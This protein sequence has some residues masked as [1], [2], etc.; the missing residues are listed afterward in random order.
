MTDYFEVHER[1]G[2]ARLGEVRLAEPVSKPALAD[3]FIDDAG[4]LWAGDREVPAGDAT[5]LTVL[6]H[7]AF[8]AGTRDEVRESFAVDHPGVAFPSAAVVDSRSARDLGADAYL[9]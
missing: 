4:S 5:A 7:R 6:H 2:A 9:L 8:P 1:D 3:P